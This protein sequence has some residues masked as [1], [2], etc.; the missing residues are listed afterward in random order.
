MTEFTEGQNKGKDKSHEKSNTIFITI[1]TALAFALAPVTNAAPGPRGWPCSPIDA[2]A[3]TPLVVT[4]IAPGMSPEGKS[5][6]SCW[7]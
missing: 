3:V 1:V 5:V 2:E 7:T 6:H 4:I